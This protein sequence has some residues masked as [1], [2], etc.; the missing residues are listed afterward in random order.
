MIRDEPFRAETCFRAAELLRR[1]KKMDQHDDAEKA[2]SRLRHSPGH[3]LSVVREPHNLDWRAVVGT[4]RPFRKVGKL[5]FFSHKV[6]VMGSRLASHLQNLQVTCLSAEDQRLAVKYITSIIWNVNSTSSPSSFLTLSRY[7]SA[8]PC[9]KHLDHLFDYRYGAPDIFIDFATLD[10]RQAWS[11]FTDALALIGVSVERLDVGLMS[12]SIS[13][14]SQI[15]S[16]LKCN[17]YPGLRN[18]ASMKAK[19]ARKQT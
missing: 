19:Y 10:R 17:V 4:S 12:P 6:F 14:W 5:S 2:E 9:L 16:G 8:F 18:T 7:I 13:T 11:H 15:E 3:E 1:Q